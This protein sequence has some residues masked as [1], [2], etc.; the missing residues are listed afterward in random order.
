TWIARGP[1]NDWQIAIASRICS[2]V[3][4]LRS[5][6]SSRS[7]WP[8]SATG[9]PNPSVP[10]RRKYF[11]SSPTGLW[12]SG[13]GDIVISRV[14]W[15][16][17]SRLEI[18]V[19]TPNRRPIYRRHEGNE[20]IGR[21]LR[22]RQRRQL[23]LVETGD[24]VGL[25]PQREFPRVRKRLVLSREQCLAIEAHNKAVPLGFEAER[26]P[27]IRSEREICAHDFLSS[28]LDHAIEAD[29]VFHRIGA[30]GVIIIG[31]DQ[32]HHNAAR[33]VHGA[34]DRLET[35]RRINIFGGERAMDG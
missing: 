24:A 28:A 4:H 23:D 18:I 6:T 26:M 34:C 15:L 3:N 22:S 30:G 21:A 12:V 31:I 33:L 2:F 9:P 10:K 8:T 32:P 11:T 35:N 29:V 7:I 1:G 27:F 25:G 17:M 13:A 5:S 20:V 19:Q 16:A 14:P